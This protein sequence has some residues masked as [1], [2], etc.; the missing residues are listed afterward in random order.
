MPLLYHSKLC[1]LSYNL[2]LLYIH[3]RLQTILCSLE[4]CQQEQKKG[5]PPDVG[6]TPCFLTHF[7]RPIT[8][9]G[10]LLVE[11]ELDGIDRAVAMLGH[12]DFS[13]VLV[14]G[15]RVVVILTIKEG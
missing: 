1:L 14:F 13:H 6:E 3:S 15:F 5:V 2:G 7:V 10:K 12:D 8:E 11:I 9:L 4:E